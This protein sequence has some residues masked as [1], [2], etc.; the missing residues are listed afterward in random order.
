[1]HTHPDM[2]SSFDEKMRKASQ[3]KMLSMWA[4]TTASSVHWLLEKDVDATLLYKA[5]S[6]YFSQA[7][8]IVAC[9][10]I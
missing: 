5:S 10:H 4:F 7:Y 6:S 2:S 1:M 8:A 3:G 9:V